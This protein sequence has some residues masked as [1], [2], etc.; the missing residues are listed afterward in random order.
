VRFWQ[1]DARGIA[2]LIQLRALALYGVRCAAAA[3]SNRIRRVRRFLQGLCSQLT[4]R[5]ALNLCRTGGFDGLRIS[6]TSKE[7]RTPCCCPAAAAWAF[8][9]LDHSRHHEAQTPTKHLNIPRRDR[10]PRHYNSDPSY[11]SKG[12]PVTPRRVVLI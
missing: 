5:R 11:R 10:Q 1:R 8:D 7:G 9:E 6:R 2:A 12:C 4:A 3:A